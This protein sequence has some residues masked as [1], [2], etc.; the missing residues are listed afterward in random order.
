ML[1]IPSLIPPEGHT[2]GQKLAKTWQSVGARGVNNLASKLLLTLLPPSHSFFRLKIDPITLSKM[3]EDPAFKTDVEKRLATFERVAMDD[4]EASG[5]NVVVFEM[6]K[7]LLVAGNVLLYSTDEGLKL[8]HLDRYVVKRDPMGRPSEIVVKEEFAFSTLPDE[9]RDAIV[10]QRG[11]KPGEDDLITIYTSVK[12]QMN[13]A[14]GRK[15]RVWQET[16]DGFTIEGSEGFHS[17]ENLPWLPLRLIRI[18]GEDYGRGYVEEYGGDLSS[19]ELLHKA[20]VEGA[21]A[22]AKVL[23]LVK[24][25]GTTSLKVLAS[26]PN[27]A[28]REG[29]ADDVTTLQ[30]DKYSDFRTARETMTIIERRLD[31]AF[32][33]HS[34]VQRQAERVTAQE[35]SYMA[36]E[37]EDALG[38]VYSLL[39]KEFQLPYARLKLW[40]L[41]KAGKIAKL[42]KEVRVGVVTG[43]QALG[44]GQD[45]NRLVAFIGT[46][47]QLGGPQAIGNIVNIHELAKR[48]ANADGIDVDELIKTA[49]EVAQATNQARQDQMIEKLGP[50]AMRQAGSQAP[51]EGMS[52]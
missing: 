51:Q 24:P 38:G 34:S 36:Q 4:I 27:L 47:A 7:H 3:S 2:P 41:T 48:L 26:S 46:L 44:R 40:S 28:I 9:V 33:N 19:L 32:L 8:F 1:T 12:R 25:N 18:D 39:T 17:E 13:A 45:R 6:N 35:V 52:N 15:W 43:L 31:T 21:V 11:N 49:E 5:D 23:F 37:L 29:N 30:L 42:P 14:V 22:A 50:A 16:S 20:L 10:A